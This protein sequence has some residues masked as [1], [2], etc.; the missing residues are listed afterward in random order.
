MKMKTI[1]FSDELSSIEIITTT[2]AFL[3]CEFVHIIEGIPFH[4][5]K[6]T[7]LFWTLSCQ[8]ASN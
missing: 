3:L 2:F 5:N 8:K 1:Y 4:I 6:N 7:F